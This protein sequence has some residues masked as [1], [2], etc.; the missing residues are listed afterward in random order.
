MVQVELGVRE[1]TASGDEL[2]R[3]ARDSEPDGAAEERQ[4]YVFDNELSD[5]RP[6]R[7]AERLAHADL[8]GAL[9]NAADVDIDQ[10]DRRQHH[11]QEH[12]NDEG[13]DQTIRLTLPGP[14]AT[15]E[16]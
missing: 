8:A 9:H 10:V 6:R 3:E 13:G 15:A 11:K 4:N 5:Q 1:P 14:V 12:R 7:R 16:R 2:Q